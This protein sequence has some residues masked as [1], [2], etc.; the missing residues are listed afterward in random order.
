MKWVSVKECLPETNE[1][2]LVKTYDGYVSFGQYLGDDDG[3][4]LGDD[5]WSLCHVWV[6]NGD[7][8]T[9]DDTGI[10]ILWWMRMPE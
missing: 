3:R 1:W 4:Y 8:V 5:D 7:F 6:T 10:E 2:V 9:N